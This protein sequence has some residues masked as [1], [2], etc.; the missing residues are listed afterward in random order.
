M[1]FCIYLVR[2]AVLAQLGGSN[3]SKRG[4]NIIWGFPES[5]M[6]ELIFFMWNYCLWTWGL[7]SVAIWTSR[8]LGS[9]FLLA[10]IEI[11]WRRTTIASGRQIVG[12]TFRRRLGRRQSA[13]TARSSSASRMAPRVSSLNSS[14]GARI[15]LRVGL[16][17]K[18]KVSMTIHTLKHGK[19]I[20]KCSNHITKYT[21]K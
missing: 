7:R 8:S 3:P 1:V 10:A 12:I 6:N 2:F 21:V 15:S 9:K 19:S 5:C 16:K 17:L 20:K 13:S 14:G 4:K 11:R 18:A